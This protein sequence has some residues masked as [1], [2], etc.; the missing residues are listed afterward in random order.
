VVITPATNQNGSATVSVVVSDGVLSATNAFTLTV[1]PVNDAPVAAFS[2]P[3]RNYTEGE[4][5]VVV[6]VGATVLDMDTPNFGAGLLTVDFSAN[7]A[8]EDRLS[9]RN[10]GV[11]EGQVGVSGI[12]V[13]YGGVG[14]GTF[15]GGGSGSSP[16]VVAFNNSATP[17][18]VQAVLRNIT[19]SN[20]STTPITAA[21]TVRA[22][23][24]DGHGGIGAPAT[25]VLTVAGVPEDPVITWPSPSPIGYGT[26]LDGTQLN[27]SASVPGSFSYTPA[28]GS[29]LGA[30]PRILS[31][32]FTPT[33]TIN[34]NTV[35]VTTTLTVTPAA[36]LVTADDKSK[37]YGSANPALTA[38]LT[39][40]VN[41]DTEAGLD[42]PVTLSTVATAASAV[43]TYSI[44]ASGAADAN[45]TITFAS[46]TLT[47]TEAG[48]LALT[49]LS[50]DAAGSATMRVTSDPGQRI[51]IQ[52]SIDLVAWADIITFVNTTGTFDH[53][54]PAVPGRPHRFYRAVLAPSIE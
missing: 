19:Y 35:T 15:S 17:A 52:A 51:T 22:V 42:T 34:Y 32:T 24:D 44:V 14:I 2:V 29:V 9:I 45:Y 40:F 7:G 6:D 26:A 12:G 1:N 3:G 48:P 21:R 31:T 53:T 23:V 33:D 20:A 38:T 36:L 10:E 5:T 25:L 28:A 8:S 41:G 49:I 46:G 43:G 13:S 37:V 50:A 39:G 16:L 27:A 4:G 30:G 18:I 11:G 47:V 54:D